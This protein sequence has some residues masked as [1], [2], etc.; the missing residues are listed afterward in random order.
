[1]FDRNNPYFKQAELLVRILPFIAEKECFAIKGGTAINLF[2]R[3]MPRLSVDIDLVYLPIKERA[4]S[5]KNIDLELKA[6]SGKVLSRIKGLESE[7]R[8]L[9]GTGK[10]MKI[11]LALETAWH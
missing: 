2:I 9:E 5:L 7:L 10:M 3:D 8:P 4:A 11:I 6:I 1:M